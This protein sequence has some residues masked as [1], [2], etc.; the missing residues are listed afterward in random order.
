MGKVDIYSKEWCNEVFQDRNKDYGAY[1]LRATAG[2][3]YRRALVILFFGLFFC[4]GLPVG[5]HLYVKYK[6]YKSAKDFTKEIPELRKL[7]MKA[8]PNHEVKLLSA[9]RSRLKISTIENATEEIG[10]I[11][12]NTENEIIIGIN[13][14]ET[15]QVEEWIDE[16]E[17]L[18]TAHNID[19]ID[20]PVEGPQLIQVDKVEEIPIFPGGN[21]A[22][23]TWLSEN[24]PYPKTCM[25]K[26]VRGMMEV[27]FIVDTQGYPAEFQVTKS[28]HPDLDKLVLAAMKRMPKWKPGKHNGEPCKVA[29]TLPLHFEP[30]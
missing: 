14:K 17:D 2:S 6:L 4:I 27:L 22:L 8:R 1:Q 24:I 3:R 7:E 15:F 11:V 23:M 19:N 21:K 26:K 20:L 12:E 30:K 25:D 18:D 5:I 13:G 28:L 29:V 10:E 9:G 16:W